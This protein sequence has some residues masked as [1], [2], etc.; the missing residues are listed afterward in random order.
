MV[1]FGRA[2]GRGD[3]EGNGREEIAVDSTSCSLEMRVSKFEEP[4]RR[5]WTGFL[6]NLRH[7]TSPGNPQ[8]STTP[9]A[10]K[11]PQLPW[12]HSEV[13]THLLDASA[14][15]FSNYNTHI[16]WYTAK[17]QAELAG[18]HGYL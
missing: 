13:I 14:V 10:F 8:I 6:P 4:G 11:C 3:R 18:T 1:V 16:G 5:E 12:N 9:T 17:I 15:I 2:G 7:S